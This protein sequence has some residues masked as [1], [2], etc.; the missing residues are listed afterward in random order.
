[1]SKSEIPQE[2]IKNYV[3]QL[4]RVAKELPENSVMQSSLILRADAVMDMVAAYRESI[5]PRKDINDTG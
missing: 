3:D 2:W 1:M 5:K 4:I